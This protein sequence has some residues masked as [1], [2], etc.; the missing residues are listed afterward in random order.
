M[1]KK[2]IS[3]RTL[4]FMYVILNLKFLQIKSVWL[5]WKVY[6]SISFH[7]HFEENVTIFFLIIHLLYMWIINVWHSEEK[8]SWLA[9]KKYL[10]ALLTKIWFHF[11]SF[12]CILQTCKLCL[13][14][15]W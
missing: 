7:F 13:L 4:I 8:Q 2:H 14:L 15:Y 12:K 10:F 9:K 11:E 3:W 1:Y 5:F 6:Q